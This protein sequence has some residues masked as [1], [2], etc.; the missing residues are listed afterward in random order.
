M[1]RRRYLLLSAHTGGALVDSREIAQSLLDNDFY[2]CTD[3]CNETIRRFGAAMQLYRVVGSPAQWFNADVVE[4]MDNLTQAVSGMSDKHFFKP[5]KQTED[6]D[7]LQFKSMKYAQAGEH[8]DKRIPAIKFVF[9]KQGRAFNLIK[10]V[11]LEEGLTN[12]QALGGAVPES[13]YSGTDAG[14][15]CESKTED[16]TAP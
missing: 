11:K 3:H 1:L 16:L 13:L 9:E 14:L 5:T 6:P 4:A 8:S 12:M 2:E 15:L 7:I 10:P